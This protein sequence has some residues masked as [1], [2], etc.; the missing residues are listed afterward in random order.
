MRFLHP[1][2]YSMRTCDDPVA[3]G[4]DSDFRNFANHLEIRMVTGFNCQ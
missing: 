4:G 1:Q 3:A 2:A